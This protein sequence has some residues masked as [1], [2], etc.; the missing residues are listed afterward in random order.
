V[1]SEAVYGALLMLA[2][3]ASTQ[4]SGFLQAAQRDAF[5]DMRL[6]G[7]DADSGMVS[8]QR[9]CVH[10]VQ[11]IAGTLRQHMRRL[12]LWSLTLLV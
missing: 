7:A 2:C 12:I 8:S 3:F 6:R 4:V 5:P 11:V 1:S 9:F 10:A